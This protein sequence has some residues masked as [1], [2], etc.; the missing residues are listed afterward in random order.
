[1]PLAGLRLQSNGEWFNSQYSTYQDTQD[2]STQNVVIAGTDLCPP[3]QEAL[4]TS[5]KS[6]GEG[7][8]S[9]NNHQDLLPLFLS[10]I[11]FDIVLFSLTL[12]K[13]LHVWA[14]KTGTIFLQVLVEG[15]ILYFIA[16]FLVNFVN[17]VL[18][19]SA[20]TEWPFD[21]LNTG[22]IGTN[23]SWT[24]D[25]VGNINVQ[26]TSVLFLDLREA[27]HRSQQS[28][29]NPSAVTWSVGQWIHRDGSKTTGGI[30]SPK[31]DMGGKQ[32]IGQWT[33]RS[34]MG[35]EDF[36]VELGSLFENHEPTDIALDEEHQG[37]SVEA[38]LGSSMA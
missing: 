20:T 24:G 25:Y 37:L 1:M 29:N 31:N 26:L 10:A 21:A 22:V 4:T 11:S 35:N 36:G 19:A 34:L 6:F 15:G 33:L 14:N 5:P 23:F 13:G 12:R 28:Y 17:V 2:T 38:Q 30:I 27:A 3:L 9:D 18:L 8:I 7:I 16:L 32:F